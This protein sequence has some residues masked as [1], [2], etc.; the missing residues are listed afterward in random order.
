[1]I[2]S[3]INMDIVHSRKI[4]NRI[5]VQNIIKNYL[6]SLSKKYEDKLLT[7]ITITLGDE[8]Q[9][10]LKDISKSYTIITE[11]NEFLNDYDIKTYSGIGIG[12]IS[13][14]VYNRSSNMDGEAFINARNALNLSKKG[15]GLINSKANR[16]LLNEYFVSRNEEVAVSL[17]NDNLNSKLDLV[18]VI[19]SL[20]ES[21]EILLN[22]ITPKQWIVIKGYRKA[23]SYNKM[24]EEGISNSKSDISQKLNS[25]EF[26]VIEN[27]IR[28]IESLFAQYKER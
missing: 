15:G 4:K 5:E 2:Y 9:I 14:E 28:I 17:E 26:F 25:A 8:W 3:V 1:M 12:S 16:V 24:V 10:V 7:P 13:T 19:N 18:S 27:N 21:T 6:K 11:I 20:I 22:K 23:G